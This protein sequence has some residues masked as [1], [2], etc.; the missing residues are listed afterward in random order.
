VLGV[1]Q[2]KDSQESYAA[3][4]CDP[5]DS[6]DLLNSFTMKASFA[7]W[8]FLASCILASPTIQS[9]SAPQPACAYPIGQKGSNAKVS[10]R[11]FD[12]DGKVQYFAGRI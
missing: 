7:C 12:I 11:L 9:S 1:M 3:V 10:G 8:S 6:W 4:P 5:F 2:Y